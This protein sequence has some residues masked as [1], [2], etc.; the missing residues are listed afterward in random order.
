[1]PRN[2]M[3]RSCKPARGRG[4]KRWAVA[5]LLA[6][7]AVGGA[8]AAAREPLA[9]VKL[10]SAIIRTRQPNVAV[11]SKT[12]YHG[13]RE[14]WRCQNDQ[15]EVIVVPEIGRVMQFRFL[16]DPGPFWE[17]RALD[18]R[19]PD[20]RSPTWRNFGGDKPWPAPQADWPK[21]TARAWP[22]PA[23]FD[24]CPM[25]ADTKDNQLILI[26]PTDPDYGIRVVRRIELDA[27]KPVLTVSTTFEKVR[28]K[29]V[30]SG[31]W[32]VTQLK[33]PELVAM[34]A[35]AGSR[36]P[37]AYLQQSARLPAD[38]R[39]Q[40]GA[41]SFTRDPKTPWK[42]GSDAGT[43]VWIGAA[44][45]LRI[46]SPRVK[47]AEYPDQGCSVELYTNPDPDAYVELETLGPLRTLSVGESALSESVYTLSRRTCPDA[48]AEAGKILQADSP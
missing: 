1:M 9:P 34:P 25:D 44:T 26:S 17:N 37:R 20:R 35:T 41:I 45:A 15:V 39:L 32:V 30:T 10:G 29:S 43:L 3:I 7:L 40:G 5:W 13:W 22:P 24:A 8:L 27:Q 2:S 38:L 11:W 12:R 47:G 42:I 48:R 16:D 33:S 23:G 6:V 21:I 36:F 4:G 46:D 19:A 28:G 31:V 14:A 18:G